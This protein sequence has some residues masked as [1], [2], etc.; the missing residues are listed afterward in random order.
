M[1]KI[2]CNVAMYT[3][4][5]HVPESGEWSVPSQN[6]MTPGG[7]MGHSSV[8]DEQT[9]LVYVYGGHAHNAVSQELLIY[10]PLT[11]SWSR[12]NR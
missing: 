1:Y 10:D 2:R 8:Y 5:V 11:H 4:S 6:G 3:C 7:R 9:G 12:R